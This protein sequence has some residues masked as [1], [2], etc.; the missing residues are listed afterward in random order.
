M[1]ILFEGLMPNYD[2]L[3]EILEQLKINLVEEDFVYVLE[4]GRKGHYCSEDNEIV[5]TGYENT[6]TLL[7][8]MVHWWQYQNGGIPFSTNREMHDWAWE[9]NPDWANNPL[10]Q[11]AVYYQSRPW[12]F[13]SLLYE[14]GRITFKEYEKLL[15]SAK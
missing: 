10:E 5:V 9:K 2:V 7:H 15:Y 3:V 11:E 4:Y 1:A 6:S 13:F 8:E 12:E 14:A